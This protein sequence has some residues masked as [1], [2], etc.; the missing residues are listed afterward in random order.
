[1]VTTLSQRFD[2]APRL[3]IGHTWVDH[4]WTPGLNRSRNETETETETETKK[5]LFKMKGETRGAP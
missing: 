2:N 1:M 4:T 3:P 5:T